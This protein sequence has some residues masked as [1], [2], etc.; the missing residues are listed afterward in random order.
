MDD[1]KRTILLASVLGAVLA[2][3]GGRSVFESTFKKPITDLQKKIDNQQRTV[4][5][6][7]LKE[8]Q[9]GAARANLLSWKQM[10]L[11]ED[12]ATAQR[13][14]REWIEQMALQCSFASLSVEPGSKN[15]LKDK[16]LSVSVDV[17][18]ETD[19]AGLSRFMF[20]FDSAAL[21]QRLSNLTVKSTGTQG[22]PRMEIGFTAEGMSVFQSGVRS[23]LFARTKL[24]AP[25][26]ETA[27]EIT[28]LAASGFPSAVPFDIR[29]DR[30]LLTVIEAGDSSWKVARGTMGTKPAA[31]AE[32]AVV[33][34]L[35]RAWEKK[36]ASFDRYES[37]LAGSPFALPSPP[38]K[39]SPKLS[40]ISDK[41]I[42]P[43]QEVKLN[44]KVDD[45]DPELGSIHYELMEAQD[46]MS[47]DPESGE[48]IWTTA[49]TIPE[50]KYTAKIVARQSDNPDLM[51]EG[52][53]TVS[54]A[55]PN[56]APVIESPVAQIAII[57]QP[58]S[59]KIMATDD[60]AADQLSFS[61]ADA[62]SGMTINAANGEITWTPEISQKP[63]D[64]SV[65]VKV[66]DKGKE[67]LSSTATLKVKL[68]EDD[69]AMTLLTGNVS[70]DDIWYAWFRNKATGEQM[71][72]KT[73][74]RL[75]LAEIDAEVAA[76]ELRSITLVDSQGTWTV[77]LGKTIRERILISPA[78][79]SE[80]VAP[81]ASPDAA[82]TEAGT[83]RVESPDSS[84]VAD[85]TP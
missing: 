45:L 31:H 56:S 83:P 52:R 4:D 48:F 51:L 8:I 16:M 26:S 81:A 66:T 18:A 60:A 25:L 41:S 58:F 62:P 33:E 74:E 54:V 76:I 1:K 72:L 71:Q 78:A 61:L 23:E 36:G 6:L 37:L 79:A 19:L 21:M 80:S 30:E 9:L 77:P 47:L 46:G 55:V 85:T 53:V 68:Q 3:W 5:G 44:V 63:N 50:G 7:E 13:L 67:P 12:A 17:K 42:K 59:T 22:N 32:D 34:L 28:P 11:P 27:A 64:Y 73:G 75:V 2:V 57:G 43:G 38:R 69:A 39:Y 70:K 65:T 35:P 49:V 29:V 10:S 20:L 14:Y 24:A 82:K 40:G 84:D 15:V